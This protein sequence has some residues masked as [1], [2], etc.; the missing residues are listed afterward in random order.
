MGHCPA[1]QI[2]GRGRCRIRAEAGSRN[3]QFARRHAASSQ[4][5]C[6]LLPDELVADVEEEEE[7]TRKEWRSLFT[8]QIANDEAQSTK[9]T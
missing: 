6:L 2:R 9:E 4:V 1:A 8:T 3:E 5:N 7:E